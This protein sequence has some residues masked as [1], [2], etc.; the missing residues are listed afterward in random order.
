MNTWNN[1]VNLEL[2]DTTLRDWA[3][4]FNTYP[5][6]KQAAL[7]AFLLAELWIPDIEIW[8]PASENQT[9]QRL[10][11]IIKAVELSWKNPVLYW[12][13]R[14]VKEDID[15]VLNKM[16]KTENKW[17]NI[18]VSWS[19]LF[20]MLRDSDLKGKDL[21]N[22]TEEDKEKMENRVLDSIKEQVSYAS[23]LF[24]E[25]V[26]V[27]F[28]DWSMW[29]KE[30]LLK[31]IETAW[32]SGA[33]VVSIPD[34]LW[35]VL[36]NEIE[37]LFKY[38]MEKTKGLQEQGLK[39]A[40]HAHDDGWLALSNTLSAIKLWVRSVEWTLLW[41]WE[42]V[43][44]LNLKDLIW[45]IA[46][47]E[48]WRL[49]KWKNFECDEDEIVLKLLYETSKII[50]EL[51]WIEFDEYQRYIWPRSTKTQVW[52]HEHLEKK[53]SKELEEL[54]KTLW[55]ITPYSLI[56][57]DKF[58]VPQ[59]DVKMYTRL[60]WF[61]NLESCLE[62]YWVKLGKKDSLVDKILDWLEKDLDN[63]KVVYASRI[64][65]EYLIQS[66]EMNPINSE[67]IDLGD[68]SVSIKRI[69]DLKFVY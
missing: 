48:S 67:D 29:K 7:I 33:K 57:T 47:L 42:R 56:D 60:S 69:L 10:E 17:V 45:M 43:W 31:A 46:S 23:S 55:R 53:Q 18:I 11:W 32:E 63:T 66:Q 24:G 20:Q 4:K 68:N 61:S 44:N 30:F 28:E 64:Y 1:T 49:V 36:P 35:W 26:R 58:W 41:S 38:L 13:C 54:L 16:K 9:T 51:L 37:D 8:V 3:Q 15:A 6:D 34:T 62:Q 39:F 22:L 40:I 2:Y 27:C 65:S 21:T 14:C 59:L 50:H 12:F 52:I 19:E 25:N 5:T